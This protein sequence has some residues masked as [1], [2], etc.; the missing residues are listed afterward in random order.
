MALNCDGCNQELCPNCNGCSGELCAE[1]CFCPPLVTPGKGIFCGIKNKSMDQWEVE[2]KSKITKDIAG[3]FILS[4]PSTD[5]SHIY[6]G[7]TLQPY[8]GE[9]HI[10]FNLT[11]NG[12]LTTLM[13]NDLDYIKITKYWDSA[14][15]TKINE[16]VGAINSWIG[17]VQFYL[18]SHKL[19]RQSK[20][21]ALTLEKLS[22]IL[23]E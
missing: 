19:M 20:D 3:L 17:M 8:M 5:V 14:K 22:C 7:V 13:E 12:D 18:K 11:E 6:I 1:I 15:V 2:L 9:K 21:A 10:S 16:A 4:V 23:D